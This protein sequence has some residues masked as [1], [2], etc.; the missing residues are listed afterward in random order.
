MKT[1]Y[2]SPTITVVEFQTH[3]TL[4]SGSGGDCYATI[5][6]DRE[7]LSRESEQAIWIHDVWEK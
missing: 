4:L 7:A 1:K 5:V 6:T 2:Q 3:N